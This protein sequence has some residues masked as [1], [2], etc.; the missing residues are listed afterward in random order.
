MMCVSDPPSSLLPLCRYHLCGGD[1]G[2]TGTPGLQLRSFSHLY[3]PS[4]LNNLPA[5]RELTPP[6]PPSLPL[7]PPSPPSLSSLP[8]Y[9]SLPPPSLP[10]YMS[11][12]PPSLPPSIPPFL[13]PSSPSQEVAWVGKSEEQLKEEGVE[14]KT[15]KFPF[16]AN[17]RAKTNGE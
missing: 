16:S 2:R 11:L 10:P 12:P 1:G 13:T 15:G 5:L 7:L 14:Y 9:M 17:S 4:E 6:S 3:T 8:T